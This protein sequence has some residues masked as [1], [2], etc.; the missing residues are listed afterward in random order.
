MQTSIELIEPAADKGYLMRFTNLSKEDSKTLQ[1]VLK[2]LDGRPIVKEQTRHYTLIEFWS[3][4]A[5]T[6]KESSDNIKYCF[7]NAQFNY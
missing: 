4:N 3:E 6:I 1:Q 5:Q 2:V 7:P